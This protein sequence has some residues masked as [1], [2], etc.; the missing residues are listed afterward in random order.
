[1]GYADAMYATG[2]GDASQY[3]HNYYSSMV[4]LNNMASNQGFD[5]GFQYNFGANSSIF[6]QNYGAMGAGGYNNYGNYGNYGG[7]NSRYPG[8]ETQ[9][10]SLVDLD[11]YQTKRAKL[12]MDQQIE[13]QQ[14][15]AS[16]EF[17][18]NGSDSAV[19]NYVGFLAEAMKENNQKEVGETYDKLKIAVKNKLKESGVY[20][21][22]VGSAESKAYDDK[23]NAYVAELYFRTTNT[24]MMD[25]LKK[26]GSG[27]FATGFKNGLDPFHWFTNK[28][29]V[30]DNVQKMGGPAPAETEESTKTVGKVLGFAAL[31][32]ALPL[33][34]LGGGKLIKAVA[35]GG[36]SGIKGLFS[37]GATTEAKGLTG[38]KLTNAVSD[39]EEKLNDAKAL[40]K[41]KV[42]PEGHAEYI[43][44]LEDKLQQLYAAVSK[45]KMADIDKI[46]V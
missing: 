29:S 15:A 23:V 26:N 38:T 24:N 5:E 32:V 3:L 25:D 12:Q 14:H 44:K 1:M 39:L 4:N 41:R 28:D 40:N 2:G 36:F 19:K 42:K 7:Y 27:A 21:P 20:E 45:E 35:K 17:K 16:A 11:A 6:G 8:S 37:K 34:V 10:M 46:K 43:S 31:A 30:A 13:L 22:P 33:A 18:V 9:N